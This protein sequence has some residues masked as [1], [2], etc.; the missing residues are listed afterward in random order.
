[1]KAL[2][3]PLFVWLVAVAVLVVVV[4]R[5]VLPFVIRQGLNVRLAHMGAYHGTV[6]D[7]DLHL[8]RGGYTLRGLRIDKRGGRP[9]EPFLTAPRTEVSVS[10]AALF[11]GH[12]RGRIGFYDATI[13][14]I[15]GRT[16]SEKQTGK[17]VD[18][19]EKLNILIPAQW[20]DIDIHRGTV[21]FRN[22]V[23]SPR[24]DLKMTDV[25]STITNLANTR[26]T[27]ESRTATLHMTAKVLG[28]APLETEA[29]FDPVH[30]LGDFDYHVR[31]THIQLVRLND[32]ARAYA[33]LDFAGGTGDFTMVLSAQHGYLS[34]YARP[35]FK[36]VQLFSWKKDVGQDR[37]GPIQLLYEAAAQGMVDLFK[38]PSNGQFATRVPI[39]G[40]IDDKQFDAL[41]AIVNTLRNA[42]VQAYK[43]Q[44][45]HL[46][47]APG[48][49]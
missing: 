35:I 34:G 6:A 42:F 5:L 9:N 29:R 38:N 4:G 23:S 14:F 26:K 22:F 47:P 1:M 39:S 2:R 27:G 44:L 45:E 36:D 37:K 21:T 31:I 18:W 43:P 48:D 32:L 33:G 3:P 20:D 28:D 7:I 24:V 30:R 40:R 46:R 25:E 12:L 10:Y 11:H 41:Q 16:E 15:D 13:N 8:W 17:G 49:S 19:S